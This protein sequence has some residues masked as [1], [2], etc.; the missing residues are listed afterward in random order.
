MRRIRAEH[1][2]HPYA[3]QWWPIGQGVGYGET[4]STRSVDLLEAWPGGPWTPNFAQ[5]LAV[6]AVCDAMEVSAGER[7]WVAVSEITDVTGG[8]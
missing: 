1:P 3:A 8:R 6:Q 7:R 5:G 2:S 4:S